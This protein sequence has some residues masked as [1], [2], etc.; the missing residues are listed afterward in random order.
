LQLLRAQ[1]GVDTTTL[2]E[3]TAKRCNLLL[4]TKEERQSFAS[5]VAMTLRRYERR[6]LLEIAGKDSRTGAIH[7][8][9]RPDDDEIRHAGRS[10]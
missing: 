3:L 5:T 8:R 4:P 1:P 9:I 7:W 10:H 2:A 6:G